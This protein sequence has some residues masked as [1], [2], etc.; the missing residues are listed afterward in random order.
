MG[1]KGFLGFV[2]PLP[3]DEST[4]D[5][6]P[7]DAVAEGEQRFVTGLL[8]AASSAPPLTRVLPEVA[9]VLAQAT[10][11]DRATVLLHDRFGELVAG[12]SRRADGTL[13]ARMWAAFRLLHS[14]MPA[15]ADARRGEGATVFL[16]PESATA[17][18]PGDWVVRFGARTVVVAPIRSHGGCSVS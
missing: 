14:S 10:G 2:T 16:Q 5:T 1:E 4:A 9:A 8:E 11:M 15:L 7:V 17:L 6:V 12:T 13:D 18:G 3:D